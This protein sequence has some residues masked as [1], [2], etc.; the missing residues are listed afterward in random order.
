MFFVSRSSKVLESPDGFA[1]I[2]GYS[3]DLW[4]VVINC[5]DSNVVAHGLSL[6]EAKAVALQAYELHVQKIKAYEQL[7]KTH[8]SQFL[9]ASQEFTRL[10][11]M[12]VEKASNPAQPHSDG[13]I[14]PRRF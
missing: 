9:E 10:I 13:R 8:G 11:R 2:L 12:L 7:H 14:I 3:G 5:G 1:T 6:D 4:K